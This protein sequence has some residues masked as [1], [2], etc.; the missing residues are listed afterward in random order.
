MVSP[1]S[2]DRV[3]YQLERAVRTSPGVSAI[4]SGGLLVVAVSGG[5]DSLALLHA[6]HR[7]QDELGLRLHGAHL[8][9]RLRGAASE[10]D[11]RFVTRTFSRLGMDFTVE[12]TDV[13]AHR[14]ARRLSLEE[15]A[16]EVRY[17]F[18]A[19]TASA[20]GAAAVALGHTSDDQAET[21]LMH[22]IRGAGLTGL[23]G[24]TP[25]ARHTFEGRECTLLRPLLRVSRE[26][27]EA[28]CRHA[29]VE[30]RRDA[31]NLSTEPTRNRIRLELIPLLKRYNPAVR[32]AL[33]R[34]SLSASRDLS[35]V[36]ECVEGV[37]REVTSQDRDALSLNRKAFRRL[38]AA[39]Q[40]HLLRRAVRSVKGDLENVEQ[41]H[42][43]SMVR[44]AVGP[45]GKHLDLPAG[46]RFSVGYEKATIGQAHPANGP[47]E[48]FRGVHSLEVPGETLI[49]GWRVE[50]RLVSREADGRE[51]PPNQGTAEMEMGDAALSRCR[52]ATL[53]AESLDGRL[54]VRSRRPGDRVQPLGMTGSKKLQ[55]FMV[56]AKIPRDQRDGVPLV[57]SKKGIAWVVGWR[58]AD[59]ARMRPDTRHTLELR[60]TPR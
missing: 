4:R 33:V 11:R 36:E 55:D 34:L 22:I 38:P 32:D 44:L 40:F 58:I 52:M 17:A 25:V 28:Y 20:Q 27:T 47:T 15:A 53:D 3:L 2:Q 10:E 59:W 7:L 48:P 50:A 24:M 51:H 23:R 21:V 6:L 54:L 41:G 30:P 56:D 9:H 46:L 39:L 43:E 18:L 5:P 60:F 49:P 37:W 45:A 14:R 57:V 1:R 42:L 31:S 12:G 35:Y 13:L 8:D 29:G 16:R 26:D 19:R